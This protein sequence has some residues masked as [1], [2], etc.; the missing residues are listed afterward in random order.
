MATGIAYGDPQTDIVLEAAE[1]DIQRVHALFDAFIAAWD[2]KRHYDSARPYSLV[3][4]VAQLFGGTSIVG[5]LGPGNGFGAIAATRWHPYSPG[6]FVT[7]PFPGYVSGHSTV[8]AACAKTIE[9]FTGADR[10]GVYYRHVAGS[11]TEPGASVAQMQ[12][13]NGVPPRG[14]GDRKDVVLMM[15]TLSGTAELAGLSRIL[16]GYHIKSD[17][18]EGLKLGRAVAVASWPRYE[19]YFAGTAAAAP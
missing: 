4:F 14:L 6:T 16:G 2:V 10:F 13:M 11:A 7:P 9:L 3:R 5:Y 19:A 8:S 15:P 18:V 1:R 12:A 17:N